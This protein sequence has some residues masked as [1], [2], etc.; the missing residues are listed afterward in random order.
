MLP[1]DWIDW[2]RKIAA[3]DRLAQSCSLCPRRCG[4]N[5]LAGER[6]FC[7]AADRLTISSIFAHHGEEPPLSGTAGSGTVFFTHCTLQC[8]FCQNF[9]ISHE[10]EGRPYTE[11]ELGRELLRLQAEGCHNINLVTPTHFL[12]WILRAFKLATAAGLHLPVV[13][14]CSGYELPQTLAILDGVVDVYLPDMKYGADEAARCY[15]QAGDY[16]EVNRQA[17]REMFRQV[18]ALR[19]DEQGIARRGLIIRHLVLPDGLAGSRSILDFLLAT[20]DPQDISISLMAQY[21]P[22][23]NAAQ[24]PRISRRITT[25]EYEPVRQAFLAAGFEGFYQEPEEMDESFL[26]D[27]KQRKSEPLTG[28]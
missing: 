21:R 23:F 3:A 16:V 4:V 5:R 2:D 14:N 15:S 18:G 27:F 7:Q 24:Y 10:Q 8:V 28:R 11:D 12:P 13:Y 1:K 25:A 20:F 9:Q 19:L 17:I 22:I 6:G 26:I